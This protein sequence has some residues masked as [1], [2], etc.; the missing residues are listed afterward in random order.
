MTFDQS[1]E[2]A[3]LESMACG[4]PAV[5]TRCGEPESLIQDGWNGRLVTNNDSGQFAQSVLE[6]LQNESLRC[7][8]GERAVHRVRAEFS[9]DVLEPRLL[10][11]VRSLDQR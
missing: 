8:M 1:L 9:R 11:I 10:E 5:V 6:L 2:I 3:V 7:E 4:V